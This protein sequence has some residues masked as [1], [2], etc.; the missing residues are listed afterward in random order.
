MSKSKNSPST[1]SLSC[2]LKTDEL[3]LT[4]LAIINKI[5]RKTFWVNLNNRNKPNISPIYPGRTKS[6]EPIIAKKD[7]LLLDNEWEENSIIFDGYEI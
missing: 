6:I 4:G 3:L 2:S 7:F 1:I 5:L